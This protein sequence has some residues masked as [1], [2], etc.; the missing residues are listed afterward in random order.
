MAELEIRLL[1]RLEVRMNG[2]AVHIPGRKERA[3]L[4]LLAVAPDTAIPRERLCGL[5]WGDR[6]E[7]QA[8]DGLKQALHRLRDAFDPSSPVPI[9]A[10][11]LSLALKLDPR[12]VDA[13][14]FERLLGAGSGA[15]LPVAAALY[16]G[17]FLAD[18]HI[19]EPAFDDWL[20]AERQRFRLLA[21][22]ALTVLLDESLDAA[23]WDRVQGLAQRLLDIDPLFEAAHRALMRSFAERGR[24]V[25]ALRQYRHLAERLGD[26]LDVEPEAATQRLHRAIRQQ[27]ASIPAASP[28]MPARPA[29]IPASRFVARELTRRANALSWDDPESAAIAKRAL[30][31]AI[32]L[33]SSYARPNSLLAVMLGREWRDSVSD[34]RS[35]LDRALALAQRAVD[36]GAGD[37]TCLTSLGYIHFERR[38]FRD[39]RRFMERGLALNPDDPWIQV[40][41]GYLYSYTGRAEEACRRLEGAR[42]LDPGLGPPWYWRSLGLAY[43]VER[44][45]EAALGCFELAHADGAGAGARADPATGPAPGYAKLVAAACCAKLGDRAKARTMVDRAFPGP[46]KAAAKILIAKIPFE[47]EADRRHLLD[48]LHLTEDRH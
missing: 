2:T 5:L 14:R 35:D 39:A 4:A 15:D 32:R 11:R 34:A 18:L 12:R 43:F 48:A 6:G 17:E 7:R 22:D 23:A 27:R 36:L 19:P 21:I 44:H 1:G 25:E 26:E 42:Q 46:S 38:N 47:R 45:Y 10:D 3:L 20:R 24:G 16:R 37:S 31:R 40:D 13:W 28:A 41:L 33:D 30:E 8:H 9:R 29:G